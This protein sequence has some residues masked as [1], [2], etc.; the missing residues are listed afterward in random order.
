MSLGRFKAKFIF[1]WLLLLDLRLLRVVMRT[2]WYDVTSDVTMMV[3]R[4]VGAEPGFLIRG[5]DRTN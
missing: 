2:V 5:D 4:R 1:L 3:G